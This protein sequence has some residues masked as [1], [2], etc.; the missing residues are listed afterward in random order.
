[1][2]LNMLK[3][4]ANWMLCMDYFVDYSLEVQYN[5]DGS[6][7]DTKGLQLVAGDPYQENAVY[8][9][10]DEWV[11]YDYFGDGVYASSDGIAFG[12]QRDTKHPA[13]VKEFRSILK[14][15]RKIPINRG[16]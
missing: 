13:F 12:I 2:L 6:V 9:I 10:S 7:K 4:I 15:V 8:K 3:S 1:M 16:G 11:G 5:E 14:K